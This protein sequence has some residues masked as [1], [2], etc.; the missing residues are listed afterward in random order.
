V[1][2]TT[3]WY[4]HDLIGSTRDLFNSTG[5]LIDHLDYST[6]GKLTYES[7]SGSDR[8]L[9][10][11]REYDVETDLQYNRARY[12]DANTGRWISQ[13]PLGFDAGDSNLYRYVNNGPASATDPSGLQE[14]QDNQWVW[15]RYT[16]AAGNRSRS[17]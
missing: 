8:Y 14:R 6:F 12:Y 1:G 3:T 4:G 15:W 16:K 10:T 13:D 7:A 9:Y 11:S 2:T 17:N 5:S